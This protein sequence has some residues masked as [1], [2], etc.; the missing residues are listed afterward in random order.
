MTSNRNSRN[1]R[2]LIRGLLIWIGIILV[3]TGCSAQSGLEWSSLTVHALSTGPQQSAEKTSAPATEPLTT[4]KQTAVVQK[5]KPQASAVSPAQPA[6]KEEKPGKIIYL[7]FDDGPSQVTP[8]ILEILK[9]EKVKATFFVLG[10]GA[11]SHPELI[12]AIWEQGHAIGNHSYNHD[13]HDLYSGFTHF[14]NQIKRTEEIVRSITGIRP[15]LVRAPGGTAGHFDDTYFYLLKQ[16]GYLVTDWNVDSGD[17]KRRGVPAGEIIAES[18][19]DTDAARV[20]LLMHD[21]GG[22]E[23][24]AKALP[25]II[26]RYKAAGYEFGVL[27]EKVKPVQFKVSS[28]SVGAGRAKPSTAWIASHINANAAL[29]EPARPLV[30]EIGKLETKLMPGEYFIEEGQ[31]IVP[32]RAVTQRLGGAVSWEADIHSVRVALNGHTFLADVDHNELIF[33]GVN[34][35]TDTRPHAVT[36]IGGNVWIG[37][38]DLLELAEHPLLKVSASGEER[39]VKAY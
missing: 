12:N 28:Q 30:L 5:M 38:R 39:R 24:T 25:E 4:L 19:P 1:R 7:T 2:S 29:F 36:M 15:Q 3:V 22:H 6:V 13:Y 20:V 23:Q 9:R 16:A 10:N 17:S 27:D 33:N 32:L 18:V 37:L 14:W 34:G 8:K 26:A 11:A 21:G 35:D 31:Y